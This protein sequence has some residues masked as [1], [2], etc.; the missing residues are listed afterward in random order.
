MENEV[1]FNEEVVGEVVEATEIANCDSKKGLIAIGLGLA[2]LG[3]VL[4]YKKVIK[5]IRAKRKA[6]KEAKVIEADYEETIV[7]EEVSEEN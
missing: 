3:G 1:M 2:A 4:L 5:P 7:E 6:K